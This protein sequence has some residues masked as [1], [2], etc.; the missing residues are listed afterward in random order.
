MKRD[1]QKE[2][3]FGAWIQL[4]PKLSFHSLINSF[5][6]KKI[7]LYLSQCQANLSKLSIIYR[8]RISDSKTFI[9]CLTS[10]NICSLLLLL[11]WNIV[12]TENPPSHVPTI[13]REDTLTTW[14]SR[15]PALGDSRSRLLLRTTLDECLLCGA[16]SNLFRKM[17]SDRGW[18]LQ[19]FVSNLQLKSWHFFESKLL[20]VEYPWENSH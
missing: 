14:L 11:V 8:M 7:L 2:M 6:V 10:V 20:W 12:C 18:N 1:E 15:W 13:A 17:F 16:H 9:Y 4:K 3:L 19:L 5:I